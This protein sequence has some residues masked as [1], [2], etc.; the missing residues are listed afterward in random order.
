VQRLPA[1]LVA[2]EAGTIAVG[3]L[4]V[5]LTQVA[6]IGDAVVRAAVEAD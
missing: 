3:H 2:V 4:S 1:V 6:P 5:F